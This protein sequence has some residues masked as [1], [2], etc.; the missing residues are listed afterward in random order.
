MVQ[1]D[2]LHRCFNRT[3]SLR[4]LGLD[5]GCWQGE[6]GGGVGGGGEQMQVA[7]GALQNTSAAK[8]RQAPCRMMKNDS[9]DI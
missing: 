3:S 2:S 1:L 7:V 9:C 6:G 8:P 5:K 4:P